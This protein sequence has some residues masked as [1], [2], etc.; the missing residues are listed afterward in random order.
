MEVGEDGEENA[1]RGEN[2]DL[3]ILIFDANP[4]IW[5]KKGNIDKCLQ[6]ILVFLNSFLLLNHS[7][8][9]AVLVNH[10]S[11]ARILFPPSPSEI[12]HS[13]TKLKALVKAKELNLVGGT[14]SKKAELKRQQRQLVLEQTP[15]SRIVRK[16]AE[17]ASKQSIPGKSKRTHLAGAMS[18]ALC[19]A[20]RVVAETESKGRFIQPRIMIIDTNSAMDREKEYVPI[21]NCIFSAIKMA[22]RIDS[23]VLSDSDQFLLQQASD[24][25]DGMYMRTSDM[26]G[27]LQTL[28][29]VFLPSNTS[30]GILLLPKASEVDYRA[31]CFC[32]NKP[33]DTGWV[34]PVCLAIF[35]KKL[36]VCTMCNTRYDIKSSKGG[37]KRPRIATVGLSSET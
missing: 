19:Y 20:R 9:L 22:M 32:H 21:M 13:K 18:L 35:C 34:C 36:P 37:V 17:I 5:S 1:R 7:N 12:K 3:L 15:T 16:L 33:V 6:Q 25:T 14:K 24:L 2:P 26:S 4:T 27:L 23:L 8:Q 28:T 31:S 10:P 11:G 30:R 29:M